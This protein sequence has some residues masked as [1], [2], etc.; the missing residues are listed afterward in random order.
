MTEYGACPLVHRHT[1]LNLAIF[2]GLFLFLYQK[3]INYMMKEK[4]LKAIDKGLM[5]VLSTDIHD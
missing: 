3:N 2:A 1:F 4:I 5:N